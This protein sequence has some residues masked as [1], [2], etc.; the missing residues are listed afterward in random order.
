M[1]DILP[2]S[3][4]S[5]TSKASNLWKIG[6]VGAVLFGGLLYGVFKAMPN[7]ASADDINA[8]KVGQMASL[9]VL[10]KPPQQ[11][12]A[13]FKNP[14]NADINLSAFKG[15]VILVNL[16]ATWCAPCVTEMPTLANLQSA[17]KNKDFIVVAVSVDRESEKAEAKDQLEALSRGVLP[18]FHDPKMAIVYPMQA[19]GFP[20][21]VLYDRHGKEIARLAGEADWNSPEAQALIKA[22]LSQK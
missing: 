1:N 18:F 15:K 14:E 7:A 13:T 12:V 11:P 4:K 5:P 8:L 22:A 16:W 10:A 21:S 19:R 3:Q 2:E 17:F 9:V 20:T 6:A